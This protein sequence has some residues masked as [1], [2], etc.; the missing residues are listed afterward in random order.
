MAFSKQT[1]DAL[2]NKARIVEGLD[3]SLFRKDACG[4]LIMYNKYGLE[5]PYGWV[6]DHIFPISLGG[7]DQ[8]ENLRALHYL[9]N[10][11]KADDYPTY[12]SVVKFDGRNN[13]PTEQSLTVNSKRREI[14]KTIYKNA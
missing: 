3:S 7:D 9:N 2:W 14:L 6:V 4:A 10:Q 5:N 8:I 12:T 1:L 11:S 13:Q